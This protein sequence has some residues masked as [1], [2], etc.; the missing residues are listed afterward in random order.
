MNEFLKFLNEKV[1]DFQMRIEIGYNKTCGWNIYIYKR[2][3]AKDYLKSPANGQDA[4]ICNV[5]SGDMELAFAE[6]QVA[7]KKWF[8]ENCGG[9]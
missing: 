1:K 9:Y 3:C 6:A 5:Q 4:V 8:L 7:V 2:D